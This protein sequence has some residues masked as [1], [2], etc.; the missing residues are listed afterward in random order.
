M[1][2]VEKK[3]GGAGAGADNAAAFDDYTVYETG[4]LNEYSLINNERSLFTFTTN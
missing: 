4:E 3:K 2:E 1:R